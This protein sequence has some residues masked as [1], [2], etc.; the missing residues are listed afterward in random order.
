MSVHLAV[1]IV[2]RTEFTFR[3]IEDAYCNTTLF[4]WMAVS[5][6]ARIWSKGHLGG[7]GDFSPL[8]SVLL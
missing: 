5:I 6:D 1:E 7:G 3:V 2:H 8:L 4:P